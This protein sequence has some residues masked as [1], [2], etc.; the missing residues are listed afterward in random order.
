M[1]NIRARESRIDNFE[2]LL[3]R[4][5]IQTLLEQL[6]VDE[7]FL[8]AFSHRDGITGDNDSERIAC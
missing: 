5:L 8:Y 6:G 3:R 4:L 1:V 2:S 7:V